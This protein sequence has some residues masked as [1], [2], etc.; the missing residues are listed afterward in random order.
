[1][2]LLRAQKPLLATASAMVMLAVFCLIAMVFDDRMLLGVN[3]WTKPLKFAVAFALYSFTLAWLL[4]HPHRGQRW[5]KKLALLFA[6]TAIIDVGFI[7]LQASRGTFSH[8]NTAED[9]VNSIGQIVFMSGVPG[10]FIA[11]LAISGILIWQKVGDRATTIAM[12]AGLMISV[13][14][15]GL[16]YLVGWAGT[17]VARDANGGLVE[18]NA[19]HTFGGVDG[20]PGIPIAGW[21]TVAGDLRIPHFL[22]IHGMQVLIVVT[23][24]MTALSPRITVLRDE[25]V[26][27]LIVTVFGSA[28]AG[29]LAITLWQALRG[30]S[31]VHPDMLTLLAAGTVIAFAVGA[32]IWWW[33]AT[34]S[35]GVTVHSAVTTG[36]SDQVTSHA[37]EMSR[38]TPHRTQRSM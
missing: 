17:Q 5:T 2:D 3:V 12:R 1:M 29:L 26:R 28:Y 6:I 19:R 10:L 21:S 32:L 25:R 9:Q 11:N 24:A 7:V 37:G 30:Q 36:E 4:Y 38:W 23:I 34:P 33:P 14:G 13:I 18:L 35:S 31:L 16:G 27:S 15:M 22:G 20:G 8:F